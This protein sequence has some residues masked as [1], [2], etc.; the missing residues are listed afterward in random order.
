MWATP[1]TIT[2]TKKARAYDLVEAEAALAAIE[3][4]VERQAGGK[5]KVGW[6]WTEPKRWSWQASV[7]FE[8]TASQDLAIDLT[9]WTHLNV[10]LTLNPRQSTRKTNAKQK[11]TP[12]AMKSTPVIRRAHHSNWVIRSYARPT[13]FVLTTIRIANA[14]TGSAVPAP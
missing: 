12:I 5:C 3:V 6:R 7:D 11:Y 2:V 13:A 9:G 10:V 14:K 1:G 4:F 8:I